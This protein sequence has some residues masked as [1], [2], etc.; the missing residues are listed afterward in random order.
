MQD[1]DSVD[2]P[3][4]EDYPIASVLSSLDNQMTP[5]EAKDFNNFEILEKEIEKIRSK[6][7]EQK[8]K[9]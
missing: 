6:A 2:L 4:Y 3:F 7:K 9:N 5:Q 8:E 1:Y